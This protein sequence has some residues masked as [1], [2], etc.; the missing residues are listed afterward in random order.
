[1]SGGAESPWLPGRD[2]GRLYLYEGRVV[3]ES[4]PRR[5]GRLSGMALARAGEGYMPRAGAKG[6]EGT[7]EA[8][9]ELA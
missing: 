4:G 7:G 2:P 8:G 6:R 5:E 9:Y 3:D 1:M